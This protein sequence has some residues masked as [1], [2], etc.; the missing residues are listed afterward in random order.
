MEIKK[1]ITENGLILKLRGRLDTESAPMLEAALHEDISDIQEVTV[2]FLNAEYVS[3]AG[4]RVLLGSTKMLKKRG[5]GLKVV[6][7]SQ[8][9][10]EIFEVTGFI[11]LLE[12]EE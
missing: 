9:I 6:H 1:E 2:D 10:R 5:I 3:S 8:S 7:L 11:D 12:I 4:L